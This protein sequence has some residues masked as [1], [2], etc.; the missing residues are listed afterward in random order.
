MPMTAS[1]PGVPTKSRGS[2]LLA[3]PGVPGGADFVGWVAAPLTVQVVDQ[4][5]RRVDADL[6]RQRQGRGGL[7]AAQ[8]ALADRPAAAGV[9]ERVGGRRASGGA[10]VG[11]A[12]AAG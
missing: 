2:T 8:H 11:L 3:P 1:Q 4:V 5:E 10:H 7:T 9:G 6:A 12:D